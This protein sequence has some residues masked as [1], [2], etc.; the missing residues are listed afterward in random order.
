M[1]KFKYFVTSTSL[2]DLAYNIGMVFSFLNLYLFFERSFVFPILALIISIIVHLLLL[3]PLTKLIGKIGIRNGMMLG[4]FIYFLSFLPLYFIRDF[5]YRIVLGSWAVLSGLARAFYKSP[6]EYVSFILTQS[7]GSRVGILR[8]ASVAFGIMS[9]I[10][11]GFA[12]QIWGIQGVVV[13][14]ALVFGLSLIPLSRIEN[15]KYVYSGRLWALTRLRSMRKN[16]LIMTLKEFTNPSSF[17]QVYVFIFVGSSFAIFGG[18]TSLTIFTTVVIGYVFGKFMDKHNRIKA[19]HVNGL[20]ASVSW[21][22]RAV[23]ATPLG[24]YVADVFY[25]INEH[26]RNE[27]MD[28]LSYDLMLKDHQENLLDEKM[29]D[30]QICLDIGIIGGLTFGLLM[31]TYLGFVPFFVATALLSLLFLLV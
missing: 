17:W 22:L 7:K 3:Q 6:Y 30:V 31:V 12:S 18:Y 13:M 24:F 14:S 25:K 20:I 16:F 23:A 19:L 21:I 9:P 1:N 2:F 8:S 4:T 29:L 10:L 28:T 26:V 5:D 15:Y 11:G 27:N